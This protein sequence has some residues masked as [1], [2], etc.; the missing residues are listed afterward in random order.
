MSGTTR[1]SAFRVAFLSGLMEP[2][3]AIIAAVFL[4]AMPG[5]TPY[6]L[7]FAAGVMV[8]ITLDELIPIAH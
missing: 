3:G 1:W 7:S 5:L 2:L 4:T 6:A 8:F